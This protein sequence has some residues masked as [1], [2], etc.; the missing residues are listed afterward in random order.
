MTWKWSIIIADL[1]YCTRHKPCKNGATCR[2]TGHGQYTCECSENF[3]GTNCETRI[4]NCS[5]EPCK[6]GATCIVSVYFF[7]WF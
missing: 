7:Y 5:Q 2:N 6:N 1:N 3:T 4:Q